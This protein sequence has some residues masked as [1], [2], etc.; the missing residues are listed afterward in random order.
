MSTKPQDGRATKLLINPTQ[1]LGWTPLIT[2]N[3]LKF[4]G[5]KHTPHFDDRLALLLMK[6]VMPK[7]VSFLRAYT[8]W[9]HSGATEER[10]LGEGRAFFRWLQKHELSI[11]W[12]EEDFYLNYFFSSPSSP[13]HDPDDEM[14][15]NLS[16]AIRP[17]TVGKR[18]IKLYVEDRDML[19]LLYLP[20]GK[21]EDFLELV[22]QYVASRFEREVWRAPSPSFL[23]WTQASG[24]RPVFQEGQLGFKLPDIFGTSEN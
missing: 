23:D 7:K 22:K 20:Y 19:S 6:R 16:F 14:A 2:F 4:S 5:K 3:A 15:E 24:L 12:K 13:K 21:E 9:R 17:V 10:E 18:T 8:G 11:L 1:P